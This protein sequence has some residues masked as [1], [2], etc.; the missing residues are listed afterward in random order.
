MRFVVFASCCAVLAIP[1]SFAQERAAGGS[2]DTQV[3]WTAL[4][5]MAKAASDKA[6]AVNT[7]VDQV[8]VCGKVGRVYAPGVAGADSNGCLD[9]MA[10]DTTTI[11]S[12]NNSLKAL[13]LNVAAINANVNNIIACNKQTKLYDGVKCA[14]LPFQ[15]E[16][17][18]VESKGWVSSSYTLACTLDRKISYAMVNVT[19]NPNQLACG[20]SG[21]N[22]DGNT[23]ASLLG[24]DKWNV[25]VDRGK[26]VSAYIECK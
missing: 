21:A 24:K 14:D 7:R 15:K 18:Y 25:T 2:L 20:R 4:S 13:T 11:T 8:V 5:D 10:V 16:T 1:C 3:T 23:T 19:T 9:A 22:C 17:E 12:I 6:T 26:Y